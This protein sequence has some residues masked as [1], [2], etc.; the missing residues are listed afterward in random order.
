MATTKKIHGRTRIGRLLLQSRD[1]SMYENIFGFFD[2]RLRR[3]NTSATGNSRKEICRPG[4]SR[5]RF[6]ILTF[7]VLGIMLNVA[8]GS[9]Y[10]DSPARTV[11]RSRPV[12]S[13][14]SIA[15]LPAGTLLRLRTSKAALRHLIQAHDGDESSFR[16]LATD[17]AVAHSLPVEYFL[18]LITQESGFNPNSVSPAGAQGIAQFMPATASDRG[19]KDP[20]D[21]TEALPK[22]AE[23]LNELREHFGNLGLAAAAYNAGPERV[24]RWLAG[25]ARLPQETLNYVRIVTGREAADWAG[26]NAGALHVT[27]GGARLASFR[28][29]TGTTRRDWEAELLAT[30][31]STA[32]SKS[33]I[34]ASTT[35][36]LD[37]DK[38]ALC[39]SCIV[40]KFY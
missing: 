23:L 30:I 28:I 13:E 8:T 26:S 29:R 38:H 39:P 25:E 17:S 2:W 11:Q 32:S 10:A 27:D 21:P 3:R 9:A 33:D 31:Q 12:A 4:P 35:T 37:K 24:R 18:R 40:Q 14:V 15:Q 22:S 1:N 5:L 36:A 20:F 16:K 7:A 6:Q 34:P 19:L